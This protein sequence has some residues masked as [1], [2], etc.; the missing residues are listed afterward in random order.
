MTSEPAPSAQFVLDTVSA[1]IEAYMGQLGWDAQP[2]LFALVPT[3]L[4]AADPA[5]APFL[6]EAIAALDPADIALDHLTPVAQ[7][8]L[9]EGPLDEALGGITWPA[10]VAGVALSQEI[11]ML[12]TSVESVLDGLEPMAAYDVA[13]HHPELKEARIIVAVLRDGTRSGLMRFRGENE[14]ELL[15]DPDL[16]PNLAIALGE[17]LT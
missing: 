8:P 14:D 12:P 9:P 1:E 5:A 17:T 10:E 7:D 3:R 15:T 13:A 4:L 16:V 6:D 11:T 2:T